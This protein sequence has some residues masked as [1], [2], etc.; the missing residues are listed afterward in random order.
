MATGG[1]KSLCYQLPAV[2][3]EGMTVVIS[4]LIA[5]MKNQVD[6]LQSQGVNVAMLNSALS[7]DQQRRIED[8][9]TRN[10]IR[11]L[12]VSPERG[13]QSDFIN[14]LKKCKVSLFAVDEAHCISMWG[15]Q[16]RPEY[17]KIKGIRES[18]PKIPFAAFTATATK[19]VREDIIEQLNL[20]SPD[21]F[22]GSFDRPNLRYSVYKEP[23]KEI[24]FQKIASYVLAHQNESGIIY[25]FSRADTEDLAAF[26]I[27]SQILAAPYHAGMSPKERN[28]VQDMFQNNVIRVVTATIA[29]GMG[30]DKPDV[31][32]IIHA[33]LPKDL[34]S[35]YQE[36]GRA[37]RDGQ[38]SE[39]I[40][41][42]SAG[43][44]SKIIHMI[45]KNEGDLNISAKIDRV[46]QLYRYCESTS[47]RRKILLAYFDEYID[48]C[49]NCD[50][51]LS[52]K[53][54][55]DTDNVLPKE[56]EHDIL[57][58]VGEMEGLLTVS[59]FA[60]FLMGLDRLK[61]KTLGVTKHSC[62]GVA[63]YYPRAQIINT[64]ENMVAEG[65]LR[66]IGTTIKRV[67]SGNLQ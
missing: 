65:K 16:F 61:T 45:E 67:Y 12:Y 37:G 28:R 24:R 54:N 26:L 39:C 33:H 58:A 2:M 17:R 49:G 60:S 22:I 5:L 27:K 3:L 41:Y 50:N 7:Y 64:L 46:M 59:E 21:V 34:E 25:C 19:R 44:Q 23:R 31:R 66:L 10:E 62:Y 40:L 52:R 57:F 42:Y 53:K 51:C 20:N 15:H 47:C 30:I 8:S 55:T 56:L 32:Y 14:L 11:I 29:F 36:T 35:Y 6:S 1:G 13:V 48:N 38:P 18:F 9:I 4:P 63:K 43:D